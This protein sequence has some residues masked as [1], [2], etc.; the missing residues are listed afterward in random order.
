MWV[1][2]IAI[3]LHDAKCMEVTGIISFYSIGNR[4]LDW[5]TRQILYSNS[6]DPLTSVGMAGAR[7]YILNTLALNT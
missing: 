6:V 4:P 1:L 2:N 5:A 7:H 3:T